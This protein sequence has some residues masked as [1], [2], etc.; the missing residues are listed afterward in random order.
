[1]RVD[2]VV[3]EGESAVD[4]SSLTGE[5]VPAEK[6]SGAE[7]FAGTVNLN[8]RLVMRVTATGETQ[9]LQ[10]SSVVAN[11]SA[12]TVTLTMDDDN[13]N[14]SLPSSY[15]RWWHAQIGNLRPAGARLG[16][17][18]CDPAAPGPRWRGHLR[19]PGLGGRASPAV[20]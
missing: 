16:G 20:R 19:R 8:G 1:M 4:E 17:R 15:R 18:G 11:G 14:H 3:V 13:A 6:K 9:R 7:L 10:S 5:S 12:W 2:G